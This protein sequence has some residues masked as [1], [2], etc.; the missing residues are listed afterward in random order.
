M[1][2]RTI[3]PEPVI[4]EVRAIRHRI[5]ERHGHDPRRLVDHYLERQQRDALPERK[6]DQKIQEG[7]DPNLV[8]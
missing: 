2:T 1:K 4:D 5:S 6:S 8:D 7:A 3:H